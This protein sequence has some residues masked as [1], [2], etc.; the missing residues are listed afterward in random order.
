ME[1]KEIYDCQE[2]LEFVSEIKTEDERKCDKLFRDKSTIEWLKER[3]DN[4]DQQIKKLKKKVL[5]IDKRTEGLERKL[6]GGYFIDTL[7]YKINSYNIFCYKQND[8]KMPDK[9]YKSCHRE[10]Y[11][12]QRS[13]DKSAV[14]KELID[15]YDFCV[16]ENILVMFLKT[17]DIDIGECMFRSYYMLAPI[18]DKDEKFKLNK[19]L[20]NLRENEGIFDKSD[21][22]SKNVNIL[23]DRSLQ[24]E[25]FDNYAL[26]TQKSELE[27]EFQM[28]D[29]LEDKITEYQGFTN[30]HYQHE[31]L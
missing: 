2:I 10:I 24:I 17:L 18:I 1:M 25:M 31:E 9:V 22:E 6:D 3:K 14:I 26:E 11:V 21:L 30:K 5:E 12:N 4:L 7:N 20:A 19:G 8:N 13:C 29:G 27:R 28:I 23:M 15:N 16:G